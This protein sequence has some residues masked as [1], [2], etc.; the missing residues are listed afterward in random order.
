MLSFKVAFVFKAIFVFKEGFVFN[1]SSVLL[2]GFLFSL[3]RLP[4][5]NFLENVLHIIQKTIKYKFGDIRKSYF[6]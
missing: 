6:F 1:V 4:H 3:P 5:S 2:L